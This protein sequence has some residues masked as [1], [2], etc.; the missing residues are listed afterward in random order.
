ML[1]QQSIQKQVLC[2]ALDVSL[3]KSDGSPILPHL[4]VSIANEKIGLVGRNGVGKTTL[5]KIL[6]GDV[7]PSTGKVVNNAHCVYLPQSFNV[8]NAD[9]LAI[10]FNKPSWDTAREGRFRAQAGKL[11]LQAIDLNRPLVTFS[12]G[13]RVKLWLSYLL[14]QDPDLVILDEPTNNLDV[15][16][17]NVL[18]DFVKHTEKALLIVSHDRELLQLVDRIVE[19]TPNGLQEF[20]GNYDFYT[21]QK[22][23]FTKAIEDEVQSAKEELLKTKYSAAKTL[24]KQV[25]K[26]ASSKRR[27]YRTGMPK[28]LRGHFQRKSEEAT[29][30]LKGLHDDRIESASQRLSEARLKL[31]K[32]NSILLDMTN[33]AVPKG[34][35]VLELKDVCFSYDAK[36]IIKDLSFSICGPERVVIRGKNGSGK[37]TLARLV[38]GDIKPI[39]GSI[40]VGVENVSYLDQQ[41]SILKGDLCLLDQF[42]ATYPEF[43]DSQVRRW[44]GRFLF[45]DNEVFKPMSVL[46][47]G[48]RIKAALALVLA[49]QKP[50]QLLILD[51]PTNNLDLDSVTQL[52]SALNNYQGALIV[53]SH[54]DAFL[55]AINVG[56]EISLG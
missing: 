13:E 46:S 35:L 31:V 49:G 54:D 36:E 22:D 14:S 43:T 27:S 52:E 8:T 11:G 30:E 29:G 6:L 18:Y 16:G 10:I 47:G 55:A 1:K 17:R 37:T 48:E 32:D 33:T 24:E 19:L 20:G 34:K 9:S 44:L 12:G 21:T 15:Y 2:T 5:L 7:R 4:S 23:T 3:V 41:T 45:T 53:I 28:Q 25:K 56:R 39:T 42:K 40:Y 51:E 38:V 26:Q 50:P